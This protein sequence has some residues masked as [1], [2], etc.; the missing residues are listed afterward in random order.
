M[1]RDP[2]KLIALMARRAI[3]CRERG[4]YRRAAKWTRK[5]GQ[6]LTKST[7]PLKVAINT[8]SAQ[9][10]SFMSVSRRLGFSCSIMGGKASVAN[11]AYRSAV[12]VNSITKDL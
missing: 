7:M 4:R 1:R 3:R 2:E 11:S 9:F 6:L 12:S 5:M 10:A 8:K